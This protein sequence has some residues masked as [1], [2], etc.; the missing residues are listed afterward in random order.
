MVYIVQH[1]WFLFQ[2]GFILSS[3]WI[4]YTC[5][6][7][8]ETSVERTAYRLAKLNMLCV[9][10]F[11]SFSLHSKQTNQIINDALMKYTDNVPYQPSDISLHDL[12]SMCDKYNISIDA[13]PVAIASGMI[14]VVFSGYDLH[15]KMPV[16]IKIKRKD[17]HS[18]L[19]T[20]ILNTLF[21][22][23]CISFILSFFPKITFLKE[24]NLHDIVNKNF[25]LLK[26]QTNFSQEIQNMHRVREN[27]LKL[28]YVNIPKANVSITNE[29][30]DIIVMEYVSGKKI[31]EIDPSNYESFAKCIVKFGIVTSAIHG[32]IHGDLH[33]G[34]ILFIEDLQDTKYPFKIGVIDFGIV[35][36]LDPICKELLFD[37][38][39]H[40]HEIPP[41]ETAIKCL[42]FSMEQEHH[43]NAQL[44]DMIETMVT[45][46]MNRKEAANHLQIY[47]ML[48]RIGTIKH[49]KLTDHFI[50]LQLMMAMTHGVTMTLCNDDYMT[51]VDKAIK[52]LFGR[53]DLI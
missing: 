17:I 35:M 30:P 23:Q 49:V 46:V 27:C 10:M 4:L 7:S 26:E 8:F 41:R 28:K 6:H 11:Q 2:L 15:N 19:Q 5:L 9:K 52:E 45:D 43:D 14:S 38:V 33:C 3:E 50:K 16:V 53:I 20:S 31:T 22:I 48:E 39:M 29:Y 21:L 34:N 44:I 40:L 18:T 37:V 25:L 42:Q 51:V 12:R 47:K 36:E 32:L 1:I 24:V 13:S